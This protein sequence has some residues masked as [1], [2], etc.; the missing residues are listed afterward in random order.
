[1]IH[2]AVA[3]VSHR[4]TFCMKFQH[5]HRRAHLH[6]LLRVIL[7]GKGMQG[8]IYG[9]VYHLVGETAFYRGG[10][11][12][13]GAHHLRDRL[14]RYF[15]TVMP[16][17]SIAYDEDSVVS[18]WSAVIERPFPFRGVVMAR[19]YEG[20]EETVLLIGSMSYVLYCVSVEYVVHWAGVSFCEDWV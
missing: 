13:I 16:S 1:M 3:Y 7:F 10:F 9:F 20:R 6:H 11:Q 17:H 5:S 4:G 15:P 8:F 14:T 19:V 2:P 18:M 12:E